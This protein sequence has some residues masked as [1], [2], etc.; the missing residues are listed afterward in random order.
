MMISRLKSRFAAAL[1]LALAVLALAVSGLTAH[2]LPHSPS[3]AHHAA[4]EPH[5]D[6]DSNRPSPQKLLAALCV[7]ACCPCLPQVLMPL[8]PSATRQAVAVT[9]FSPLISQ[10][11]LPPEKPP[12]FSRSA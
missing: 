5:G 11:P 2:A 7:A 4:L 9:A 8:P 3:A 6:H 12:R 1:R 10:T